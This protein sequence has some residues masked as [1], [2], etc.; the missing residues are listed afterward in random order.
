MTPEASRHRR[1]IG[2]L[3][4]SG[5]LPWDYIPEGRTTVEHSEKCREIQPALSDTDTRGC[6]ADCPAGSYRKEFYQIEEWVDNGIGGKNYW[7]VLNHSEMPWRWTT[8]D[9]K[10][11]E[12]M[13]LPLAQAGRN[14]R[15]VHVIE[16]VD[17]T[18]EQGRQR[19]M[20]KNGWPQE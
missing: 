9:Y 14:V 16:Q 4:A 6:H 20:V 7:T 5:R 1:R 11:A 10:E 13:F 2:G 8:Q 17:M 12:A 18:A 15:L 3:L 19:L